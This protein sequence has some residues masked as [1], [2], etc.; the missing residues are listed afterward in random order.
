[1]EGHLGFL[2][3]YCVFPVYNDQQQV[4]DIVVRSASTKS[5][6]RYVVAPV[7]VSGLRPLYCPSWKQLKESSVVYV[8]FGII[9]SI[10]LHLAGLSSISGITGKSLN[11]ELLRPLNKRLIIIPD[12]GEEREAHILANKIGWKAKVKELDFPEFTKDTDDIRRTFGNEYLLQSI[13]V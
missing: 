5:T 13:G 12:K 6:T 9:D 3:G 4:V 7:S 2:D 11:V 10:A 8:V 1:M